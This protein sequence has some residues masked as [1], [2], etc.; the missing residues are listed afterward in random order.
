MRS[1]EYVQLHALLEEIR[2]TVD[3]DQYMTDAFA[4][5]DTQPIRP[6]HVHRSK[7]DHRRA[8]FLLLAGIRDTID[9]RTT[10]EV[11]ARY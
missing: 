4:A 1:Q 5:Y 2:S 9:A 11:A 7:A 10:A 8:I 6:A 3:G